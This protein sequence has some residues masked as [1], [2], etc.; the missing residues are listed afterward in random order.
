M[1]TTRLQEISHLRPGNCSNLNEKV[2][3]RKQVRLNVNRHCFSL[4]YLN[5]YSSPPGGVISLV[6]LWFPWWLYVV[7][8]N[9]IQDF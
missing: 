1:E 6:P 2:K 7:L 9:L 4:F 5:R 3:R 8:E